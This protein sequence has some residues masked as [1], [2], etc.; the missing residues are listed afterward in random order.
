VEQIVLVHLSDVHFNANLLNDRFGWIGGYRAHDR[1]LCTALPAAIEDIHQFLGLIEDEHPSY[2]VSGDLTAAGLPGEFS[3]AQLYFRGERPV[4]FDYPMS[5]IGLRLQ[6]SQISMIP[7]NHDHW[8]GLTLPA[9]SYNPAIFGREFRSTPWK[10]V[11]TSPRKQLALELFALDS[12]SG[13]KKKASL[14]DRLRARGKI[15]GEEFEALQHKLKTPPKYRDIPTTAKFVR[16]ITVHHPLS[17]NTA[18]PL[19]DAQPLDTTSRDRL[20]QMSIQY[21]LFAILTGHTHRFYFEGFPATPS[22]RTAKVWEMRCASTFQGPA[23]DAFQGFLVHQLKLESADE[24]VWN[25]WLYR[26]DG[27]R[28][29]RPDD[30]PWLSLPVKQ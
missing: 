14:T 9:N 30:E 29:V 11:L 17:L 25:I 23:K 16:A 10:Q 24:I 27:T 13:M 1:S 5:R 18:T 15:D 20:L 6:H 7:G 21:N 4:D 19:L 26:W 22:S 8:D 12:N 2:L 3:A 28:F